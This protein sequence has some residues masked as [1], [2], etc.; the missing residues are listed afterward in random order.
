W[1]ESV[2]SGF[3][4][5]TWM[6][7]RQANEL[8]AHVRKGESG[9]TVVYASR[10]T[11]TVPD[12]GGGEVER[13]IPFLKAYT[14]FNCD[15]IDGL[16]DHYYSRPEPIAKPLERIEHADRFFD[17]TGAV[18]R[19][20]G[21]K[22]Y[23]SPASDHIQLPL[24]EQFRDMGSFVATRAH[25]T[26]HWAGGPARLNRDLS[27]YHKDR[28]ERAFEE[29]LVELGSAMLCADLGIVPELAPRPDHAAY[30]QSWAEILGSDKRA[31][32]NAAAHAQRAVAYLHDLQPEATAG[33]EAA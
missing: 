2:A 24:L 1:S 27:R 32:F 18:V 17:N 5:S 19:Y 7:L 6:T 30:I 11:K 28:R 13:D 21:D 31:I 3:M 15:Q 20:G 29:M 16:A 23:Y 33:Q 26:L 22:A 9:A 14:V 25:E 8:G 10:F 12:A 4:S